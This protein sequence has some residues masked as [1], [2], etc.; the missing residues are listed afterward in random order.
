MYALYLKR[1]TTGQ[2]ACLTHLISHEGFLE[3]T[4]H[5]LMLEPNSIKYPA[6]FR[7]KAG[8]NCVKGHCSLETK[9]AS[10]RLFAPVLF[11]LSSNFLFVQP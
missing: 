9:R 3:V 4:L 5:W 6:E 1:G 2:G 10:Q 11:F 7:V 8:M